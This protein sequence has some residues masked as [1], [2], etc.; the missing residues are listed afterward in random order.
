MAS[1]RKY[2]A[3]FKQRDGFDWVHAGYAA[4]IMIAAVLLCLLLIFAATASRG[5]QAH[6]H[7]QFHDHYQ[8][9]AN[10]NGQGC[11]NNS[12]CGTVDDTDLREIGGQLEL[13]VRGV[14][15]AKGQS[16]W[17]PVLRFHY[18]S[19]GNAPNWST[20]HACITDYYGAKT[21]CGQ[22]ICFQPKPGG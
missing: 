13:F 15:K 5:E 16:S 18:L 4:A 7:A 3:R 2:P 8:S 22:F 17:C 11:C 21:P 20:A 9:W 12:H 10:G 1:R 19:R 6:H 14:G